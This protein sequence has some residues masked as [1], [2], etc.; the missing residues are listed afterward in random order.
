MLLNQLSRNELER[1]IP[2]NLTLVDVLSLEP[3]TL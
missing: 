1:H 2:V 3:T